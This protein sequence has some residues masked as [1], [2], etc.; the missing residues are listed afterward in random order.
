MGNYDLT[1]LLIPMVPA[2]AFM[3]WVI[4]ALEKE[5]RRNSR[6]YDAIARAKAGTDRSAAAGATPEQRVSVAFAHSHS[7]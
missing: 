4:W 7:R 1:L 5:I 3:L 2:L 6:H